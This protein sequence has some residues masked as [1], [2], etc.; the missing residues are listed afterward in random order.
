MIT[1]R[2]SL[3]DNWSLERAAMILDDSSDYSDFPN[4]LFINCFD[5]LSNYINS[6]LLYDKSFFLENGF[7]THWQRLAWFKKNTNLY[8]ESIVPIELKIDWESKESYA[9]KGIKNYLLSSECYSS[10]LFVSAERSPE[11]LKSN[12][13]RLDEN[14]GTILKQIDEKIKLER[15]AS[16]FEKVRI[17]IDRNF[18]FPSLTQYV[19]SEAS[20]QKDL[21][22]VIFQLKE[23]GKIKDVRN[24]IDEIT[25]NTKKAYKFQRDIE[26]LIKKYF[27]GKSTNEKTWSLKI[28]I[29]FLTITKS[30]SPDF[31]YRK[32]HLI[33]LKNLIACRSE[34]GKLDKDVKRIFGKQPLV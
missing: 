6:L 2:K 25:D 11:I 7:Q 28:P 17:G 18:R 26:S 1:E 24:K 8:F 13:Q 31:F 21:L 34:I 33:F 5:G 14:F 10:D 20:S 19:L 27:G 3:I 22:R 30:F 29:L 15:D 16:W 9:D 32:E 12:H 4:E 23:S